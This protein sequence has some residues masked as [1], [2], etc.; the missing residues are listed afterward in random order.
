MRNAYLSHVF[1]SFPVSTHNP[2]ET[3][4]K[5]EQERVQPPSFLPPPQSAARTHMQRPFSTLTMCWLVLSGFT[6][7][8]WL[9]GDEGSWQ[10]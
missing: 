2:L 3:S 1:N 10:L 4:A 9:P 6:A 5:A 7:H 8:A